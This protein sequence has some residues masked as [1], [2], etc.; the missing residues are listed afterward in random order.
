MR[1]PQPTL[2]YFS[3][4]TTRNGNPQRV[5]VSLP[6]IAAIADDAHYREPPPLPEPE[7][8]AFERPPRWSEKLIRRTLGR[9]RK[10]AAKLRN[11][12][13]YAATVRRIE[14]EGA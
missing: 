6:Y 9:D 10:H 5:S 7:R 13:A 14:R 11:Q 1:S 2:T 4:A 8:L 12:L 3:T